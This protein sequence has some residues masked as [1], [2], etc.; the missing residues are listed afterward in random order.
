[1]NCRNDIDNSD[2]GVVGGGG[3]VTRITGP[4]LSPGLHNIIN[5]CTPPLGTE[6]KNSFKS[7]PPWSYF[8]LY[9]LN[10]FT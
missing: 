5:G 2:W 8:C 4:Q 6:N 3:G 1:M 10:G 9:I 7:C